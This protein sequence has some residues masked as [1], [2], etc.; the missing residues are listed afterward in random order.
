MK[1]LRIKVIVLF[2]WF[3]LLYYEGRYVFFLE[4]SIITDLF[5]VLLVVV[6]L[7]NPRLTRIPLW[8]Q[9]LVP[10]LIFLVV[11]VM[12]LELK[13]ELEIGLT[14]FEIFAV[15]ITTLLLSWMNSSITDYEDLLAKVIIGKHERIPEL[16]N[17]GLGFIYREVRRA[18]NHQRPLTLLAVSVNEKN[19]KYLKERMVQEIQL[20][21]QKQ[22]KLSGLSKILCD[23][24]EDCAVIVQHD[25]HFIVALPETSFED[26]P[27]IIDRLEKKAP[28]FIGQIGTASLPMD[29]FTFEGLIEKAISEMNAR[30]NSQALTDLQRMPSEK[31]SSIPK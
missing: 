29:S 19:N 26:V 7:L 6:I 2:C 11:K 20:A 30:Q 27:V 17:E 4:K 9:L 24:L 18:R 1:H 28:E 23:E 21:L 3:M 31:P 12:T 16:R 5:T 8:L 15:M 25:D 22:F 13:N 14:A 10:A